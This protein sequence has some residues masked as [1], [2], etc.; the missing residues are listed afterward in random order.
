MVRERFARVFVFFAKSGRL[1]L[2][3]FRSTAMYHDQ[4]IIMFV[5]YFS[6]LPTKWCPSSIAKLVNITPITMWYIYI[7][8]M[9][10]KPTNITGGAPACTMVPD[11]LYLQEPPGPSADQRRRRNLLGTLQV[12]PKP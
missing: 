11:D 9:V 2:T 5:R 1:Q 10:Y 6:N 12:A 8:T 7:V 3:E 4:N